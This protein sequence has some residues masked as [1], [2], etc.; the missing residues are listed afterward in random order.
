MRQAPQAIDLV[1]DTFSPTGGEARR[2]LAAARGEALLFA[3]TQRVGF[4][5][6]SSRREHQLCTN[7]PEFEASAGDS[8]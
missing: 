4:Q 3:G 6:V 7:F 8:R 1:T 2:L 5:V